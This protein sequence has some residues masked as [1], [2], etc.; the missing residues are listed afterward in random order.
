ME[1]TLTVATAPKT[2]TFQMRINPEIKE[3]VENIYAKCGMTFTDAVNVF[4]Q[5]SINVEGLPFMVGVDNREILRAAAIAQ[6]KAELEK[7]HSS[8]KRESDWISEEEMLSEFGIA[9]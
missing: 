6:L 8:V 5:Q 1:N 3:R 2:G 9:K 4:I 7:G